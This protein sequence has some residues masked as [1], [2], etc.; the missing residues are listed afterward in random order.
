MFLVNFS[1]V[2]KRILSLSCVVENC[3]TEKNK[4]TPHIEHHLKTLDKHVDSTKKFMKEHNILFTVADKGNKTVA[5]DK[6]HYKTVVNQMLADKKTYEF[7][8]E[9][10][11]KKS[12]SSLRT[13]LKKWYDNKYIDWEVDENNK[14]IK[15]TYKYIYP[16]D[17]TL[18]RCYALPKIHK[19]T[20]NMLN[21][22]VPY[23]IIVSTI[24][25]PMYKFSKFIANLITETIPPSDYNV[26]NSF[27][28]MSKI[29]NV[30]IPDNHVLVSFDV[31]SLFTN[32][33]N[34]R[35]IESLRKRWDHIS[36][37]HRIPW[38]EF[39]KGLELLLKSTFFSFDGKIYKQKFGM[40]MGDSSSPILADIVL[41]DL[42][43]HCFNELDYKIP[44]FVR[45]VD[46]IF[47]IIPEN[48]VDYTF[49]I[50][51]K[52]DSNLQFTKET[53]VNNKLNFFGHSNNTN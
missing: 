1:F 4:K 30:K 26:K 47:M 24:D 53:E 42:Q 32:V 29:K 17:A 23:R 27:E 11:T 20:K 33:P 25:S 12:I 8:D 31:K 5:I 52:Y 13:L 38:N 22:D 49:D 14:R 21:S 46:D 41:Q 37:K 7:V 50:F 28:F 18:A 40:P 16:S 10:P 36:K 43:E 9:D 6:T 19:K 35:I 48:K 44:I 51:N 34:T 3:I 15:Q 39:E 45:Y 2:Q